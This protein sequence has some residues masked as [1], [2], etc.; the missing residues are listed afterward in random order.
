LK[1]FP[2]PASDKKIRLG[3][4]KFEDKFPAAQVRPDFYFASITIAKFQ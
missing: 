4:K 2:V 3:S 1:A